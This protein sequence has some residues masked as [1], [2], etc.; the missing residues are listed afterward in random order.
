MRAATA[1]R[2]LKQF[3]REQPQERFVE[4]RRC[5]PPVKSHRLLIADCE[6][7]A[8]REGQE[9]RRAD[10]DSNTSEVCE[11]KGCVRHHS[12]QLLQ[13]P[14]WQCHQSVGLVQP[15]LSL[16]YS[17]PESPASTFDLQIGSLTGDD[18]TGSAALFRH[19]GQALDG[20][21]RALAPRST[22]PVSY[23]ARLA[24]QGVSPIDEVRIHCRFVAWIVTGR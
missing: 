10:V 4:G 20:A 19:H 13:D 17:R 18:V 3:A 6:K 5:A 24:Q 16:A 1:T 12:P 23:H 14:R 11:A 2:L 7:R 9:K 22:G 21:E 8:S 15:A